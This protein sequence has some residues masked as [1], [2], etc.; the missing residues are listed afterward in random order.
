MM[1]VLDFD[2]NHEHF[3]YL[4]HNTNIRLLDAA[5]V[6]KHKLLSFMSQRLPASIDQLILSWLHLDSWKHKSWCMYKSISNTRFWCLLVENHR[7]KKNKCET[8]FFNNVESLGNES[9]SFVDVWDSC[10]SINLSVMSQRLPASIDQLI[11]LDH[12]PIHENTSLCTCINQFLTP[13]FDV[14]PVENHSIF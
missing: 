2:I 4:T 9:L 14:C 1:L 5:E 7:C 8:S 3:F 11:C 13:D 6:F 10:C 12:I